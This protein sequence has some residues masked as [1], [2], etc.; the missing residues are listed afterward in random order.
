MTDETLAR[1]QFATTAGFH[2]LFVMLTLG[3]APLIAV[4]HTRHALRGSPLTER[5]TRFWGQI[6]V[7]NYV[8]GIVT[9]LVME[10][11]FG[12]AWSGLSEYAGNVFG[13]P[14][15]LETIVAFFAEST[16]LGMWIF[17]WG[18]LP[19][20]V[21]VT[22]IWLVT[23]TAYASA[24]WIMVANGFLQHPVG[25]EVRDG[26]ARLADF[27]AMLTNP[28]A[29]DALVHAAAAA[30]MTGGVF[31]AGV[32]SYH[33][34]KRTAE[35][36]FF[37]ASLRLGLFVATPAAFV[38]LYYGFVQIPT[39]V[40]TQPMK[41]ATL[42]GHVDDIGSLR[43]EDVQ[44]Q[45]VQRFGAGDY[46]PPAWIATAFDVM[47]DVGY[48]ILLLIVVALVLLYRDWYL[49]FRPAAYL[50]LVAVPLPFVAAL[51]GWLLREVGRQPWAVYG[52]LTTAAARSHVGS[53]LTSLVLFGSVFLA[54]AIAD[55]ALITRY[56][57]RGPADTDLG[58]APRDGH[59]ERPAT[60]LA[61]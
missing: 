33:F 14:L 25:H 47:Q 18:R 3:L 43:V 11:Q 55:W 8:L 48:L 34:L 38:A 27:G 29:I 42:R 53:M 15:A 39:L 9:G 44:A 41:A 19:K 10:F 51:G 60:S 59:A 57:R 23:L 52:E 45:L 28:N 50:M 36:A 46:R 6:Y 20:A 58:G 12:L 32:S 4:T 5:M 40:E 61:L 56:A 13:A 17:G 30:L 2:W 31:M 1:L 24:Y 37:R 49:R 26:V 35:R 21:H 7:V 22:L 54:L 16:F